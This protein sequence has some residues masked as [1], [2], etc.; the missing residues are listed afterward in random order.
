MRCVEVLSEVKSHLIWIAF[1]LGAITE[2]LETPCCGVVG[3]DVFKIL[4]KKPAS[5]IEW[6]C[7]LNIH[8]L[9]LQKFIQENKLWR[10]ALDRHVCSVKV[11]A[12]SKNGLS[13][14]QVDAK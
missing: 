9:Q 12:S 8:R 2:K 10:R 4:D 13:G 3:V 7:I 14:P 6:H 5:K 11:I 1:L